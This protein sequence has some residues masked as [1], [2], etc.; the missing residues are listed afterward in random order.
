MK[1]ASNGSSDSG[2]VDN[3]TTI[4]MGIVYTYV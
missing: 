2:N 3:F 1:V 4:I